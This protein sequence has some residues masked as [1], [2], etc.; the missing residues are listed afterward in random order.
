M[1][2]EK[3]S[4]ITKKA[5]TTRHRIHGILSDENYQ[6]VFSD[7]PGFIEKP[8]Y[9]MQEEMNKYVKST[10]EDADVFLFLTELGASIEKQKDLFNPLKETQTPVIIV[11]NKI[12][13]AKTEN[14]LE[15]YGKLWKES[16]PNAEIIFVSALDKI[17]LYELKNSII[18]YLPEGPAFYN[19]EDLSDKNVRFFV[20]EIIREKLLELYKQEI[21]YSCHVEV[22]AYQEEEKLDRIRAI[23]YTERETQK[24]IIIGK[25]GKAIK[26]LGT[27]ARKDIETFIDKKVY[28]ELFVKVKP[29]WRNDDKML[30]HFG[31]KE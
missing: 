18:N 14:A 29:D 8:A 13:K 22:E 15:D 21:P 27:D 3:L 4:I 6:I 24:S 2:G 17:N 26:Q 7:T 30:K 20:T 5:Q 19:K 28:L 9:K 23:I 16:L 25:G 1:L 11:I 10:F 31:Y 12:D